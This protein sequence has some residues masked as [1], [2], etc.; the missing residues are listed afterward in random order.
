M[1]FFVVGMEGLS[2]SPAGCLRFARRSLAAA[3]PGAGKPSTGRFAAPPF[4]P[5]LTKTNKK[6]TRW[7]AFC[8][9]GME[10]LEPTTSSM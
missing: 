1:R 10:G 7:A 9:V 5:L 3:L 2:A 8:L 4:E 6:A